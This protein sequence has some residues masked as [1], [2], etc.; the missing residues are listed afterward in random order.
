ADYGCSSGSDTT[1]SPNPQCSDGIDNNGNGKIDYPTDPACVS[2]TDGNEE[3][4]PD[5]SISLSAPTL[6]R[7]QNATQLSWSA[8]NIEANSC[9]LS[10][11]NGDSWTLSGAS[12]TKTSSALSSETIFTLSCTDLNGDPVS[13]ATTVK[14]APSF[15]EI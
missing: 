5:A 2:P 7:S 13:T 9:S 1:E 3:V 10:G 12:G 4:L 14:I 6:V 11:T 8:S 15:D